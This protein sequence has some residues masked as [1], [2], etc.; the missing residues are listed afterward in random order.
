ML[1]IEDFDTV[2]PDSPEY[3]HEE[4]ETIKSR[5]TQL[6]GKT[7]F[8]RL[9]DLLQI[10]GRRLYPPQSP[11]GLSELHAKITETPIALHYKHCLLFYL[12]KDLSPMHH[13]D[14][15]IATKF[16][17]DV[18]L[19]SKFWTFIEGLWALDH[20]QFETAVQNLTH[21]SIIPTFPDEIMI[22][23]LNHRNLPNGTTN[24]EY[25]LPMAYYNCAKPPLANKEAMTEFVKYMSDRSVTETFY[26]IRG[27]AQHEQPLLF[28]ILVSTTFQRVGPNDRTN[29]AYKREDRA[30]ELVSLPWNEDEETW[31]E[32]YLLEGEGRNFHGARETVMMRRLATGKWGEAVG[33]H[34]LR[35]KNKESLNW[36]VLKDGI[37]KGL[38]P[39][40][41]GGN[42]F[43][44]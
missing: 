7:F 43:A 9:L 24:Q 27:R 44:I 32:T 26:W 40:E 14:T 12:L 37:R 16:A 20:L 19:D 39:R 4:V 17:H 11:T 42:G 31:L 5:R 13:A 1:D 41:D 28:E 15:E 33:D 34:A 18:H 2:F 29:E 8:E 6:G 30:V 22:A 21:P 36:E 3:S 25:I 38:G 23:L 35:G 10:K